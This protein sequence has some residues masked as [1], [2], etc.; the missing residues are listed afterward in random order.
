M[1]WCPISQSDCKKEKCAWWKESRR[2]SPDK[3]KQAGW[4]AATMQFNVS[5]GINEIKNQLD[6]L[7]KTIINKN[8][9]E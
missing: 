8:F 7:N 5:N 3:E 2:K 1:A 9:A 4:C 6:T